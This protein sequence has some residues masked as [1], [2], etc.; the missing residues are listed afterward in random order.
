MFHELNHLVNGFSM[1]EHFLKA[2]PTI[3][4]FV[5]ALAFCP[6]LVETVP[7]SRIHS[8]AEVV[9]H[10]LTV[11]LEGAPVVIL[12]VLLNSVAAYFYYFRYEAILK[13][14]GTGYVGCV[15]GD[16]PNVKIADFRG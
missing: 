11:D 13:D 1:D 9:R 8:N 7:D 15:H 10:F 3:T 5:H 14:E 12:E 4:A 16:I 2:F 6:P